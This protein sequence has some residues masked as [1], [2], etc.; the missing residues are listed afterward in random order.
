[1]SN[2]DKSGKQAGGKQPGFKEEGFLSFETLL[3][4]SVDPEVKGIVESPFKAQEE[5]RIA[6]KRSDIIIMQAKQEAVRLKQE[7]VQQGI[8]EG[9][10]QVKAD[11]AQ[12]MKQ[13]ADVL[14]AVQTQRSNLQQKYE[15]DITTLVKVMVEHLTNHEVT[16]SDRVIQTCL[17]QAMEFIVSHSDVRVR[18]NP[19]DYQRIKTAGLEDPAFLEGKSQV[20]L[21]EDPTISMGGCF[22]E[23]S[24]GEIDASLENRRDLLYMAFDEAFRIVMAAEGVSP[25]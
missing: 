2:A 18:L 4:D 13:F 9:Q 10:R 11:T 8:S 5:N 20:H 24:F 25:P 16:I 12:L 14:A 19:Q 7:A 1:M 23:S 15:K 21:V 17:K 6:R 22:L 3:N